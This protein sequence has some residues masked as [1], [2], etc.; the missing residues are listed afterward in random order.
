MFLPL[1]KAAIPG[2]VHFPYRPPASCTIYRH[3]RN[4]LIGKTPARQIHR[5]SWRNPRGPLVCDLRAFLR[6][7]LPIADKTHPHD[8]ESDSSFSCV[9]KRCHFVPAA[10][11]GVRDQPTERALTFFNPAA[12][13]REVPKYLFAFV[14][15]QSSNFRFPVRRPKASVGLGN[16][17]NLRYIGIGSTIRW[18]IYRP[19]AQ[20]TRHSI[21]GPR[22][23]PIPCPTSPRTCMVLKLWEAWFS[24]N[25]PCLW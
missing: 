2:L 24:S 12:L 15:A 20:L 6:T 19:F 11:P 5:P 16:R 18:R 22:S 14:G 3:L 8:A 13:F 23:A 21:I 1:A 17:A 9:P 7:R 10:G 25:Q 4:K